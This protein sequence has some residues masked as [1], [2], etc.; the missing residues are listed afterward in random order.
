MDGATESFVKAILDLLQNDSLREQLGREGRA[1]V[2]EHFS[3]A[4]MGNA[5]WHFYQGLLCSQPLT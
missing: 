1:V 4:A 5:H 2:E 3:I